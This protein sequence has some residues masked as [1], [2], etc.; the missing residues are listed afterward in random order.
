VTADIGEMLDDLGQVRSVDRDGMLDIVGGLPEQCREAFDFGLTADLPEDL[1]QVRQII[2]AGLGGSAIGGDLVRVLVAGEAQVPV[3][4]CRDYTLPAFVGEGSLVFLTSYSGNTEETLSA[5]AQAGERG[6]AR[7]V[8][9]TGGRLAELADQ[10]NAPLVKVPAG[11]PPRSALG[12]LSLTVYMI[13]ARLGLVSSPAREREELVA[14]L[15]RL[16]GELRPDTP[17][18]QNRA[19]Q[20]AAKLYG[21]IPVIYGATGTTEVAATRWKGQVN[22]NAKQAAFWNVFP[23]LNHNELVGFEAPPELLRQFYYIFLKDPEDHPR[24]KL[25]MEIV[26][27]MIRDNVAGITD[28]SAEGSSLLVRVFSLVYLGDYVSVYLALLN[29]I[30]PKPVQVIDYLKGRLAEHE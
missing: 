24:V 26:Q 16:R 21:K 30:N 9:T 7:M 29:G 28:L 25:R 19:K 22:E 8:L 1:G 12:Y 23:E 2:T 10:D 3:T 5:Y 14:T 27:E 11:L 4:V 13:I 20:L 6:A 18:S 17:F 15:E